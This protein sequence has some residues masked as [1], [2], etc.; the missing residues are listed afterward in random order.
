MLGNI[1]IC[2]KKHL[3]ITFQVDKGVNTKKVK[4]QWIIW[5]D[6]NH[7]TSTSQTDAPIPSI[8]HEIV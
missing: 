7:R 3:P 4:P 6:G 2:S 8:N 5:I 1:L